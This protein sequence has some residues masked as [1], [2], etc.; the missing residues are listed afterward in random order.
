MGVDE[1]TKKMM[2]LAPES[3]MICTN[4]VGIKAAKGG[5]HITLGVPEEYIALVA[6]NRIT[7]MLLML[8]RKVLEQA[9]REGNE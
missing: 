8:D 6:A 5:A 9:V 7:P 3:V 4:L 2:A 1:L